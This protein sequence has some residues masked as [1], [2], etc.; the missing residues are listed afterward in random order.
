[1]LRQT[2][3]TNVRTMGG[4][5][6]QGTSVRT[7]VT[8]SSPSLT[9]WF[10]GLA[11]TG[12]AIYG[13]YTFRVELH[14]AAS[15]MGLVSTPPKPVFHLDGQTLTEAEAWALFRAIDVSGDGH[16]SK[17]ELRKFYLSRD[18]YRGKPREAFDAVKKFFRVH[19][20]DG[21]G[22]IDF[23]EFIEALQQD[24]I[25]VTGRALSQAEPR[26]RLLF[27]ELDED[28]NGT[29]DVAE[30]AKFLDKMSDMIYVNDAIKSEVTAISTDANGDGVIDY[31][32]FVAVWLQIAR[33]SFIDKDIDGNGYLTPPE[34]AAMLNRPS[35]DPIRSKIMRTFDADHSGTLDFEEFFQ[36]YSYD[37]HQQFV[38]HKHA[39]NGTYFMGI[40]IV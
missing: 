32:E 5:A 35:I 1:M 14:Q 20:R 10:G 17:V 29:V 7:A 3:A 24:D 31:T 28:A 12:G 30:F 36:F 37:A 13:L 23:G 8:G 18:K 6:R 16:I 40:R 11:A 2:A 39:D 22:T 38:A 19:D 15:D 9:S 33:A 25:N 27:K 34:V 26:L 4:A 21:D